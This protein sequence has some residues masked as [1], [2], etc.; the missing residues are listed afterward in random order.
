MRTVAEIGELELVERIRRGLPGTVP[1]LVQ[2]PGDDAAVVEAPAGRLVLTTDSQREGVHFRREQIDASA[3]GWRSLA[4]NVSDIAAMGARPAWA[5][6]A[7]AVPPELELAWVDAFVEGVRHC[8][9]ELGGVLVGGDVARSGDGISVTISLVGSLVP[10]REPLLRKGAGPGHG[11]WV[12]GWPGRSRAGLALL[13]AGWRLRDG[14]ARAPEGATAVEGAD[15][16]VLAHALPRPRVELA[17]AIGEA[18]LV[19][20][21][22]DISDGLA[23]DLG[24]LCRA[25]GVGVVVDGSALPTAGL[26]KVAGSIG[27]SA[28]EW[29][30]GGGED[31]ELLLAVA[32]EREARLRRRAEA[33]R[34]PIHRIG[35]FQEEAAVQLRIGDRL[36]PLAGGWD[37]F[38]RTAPS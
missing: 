14:E 37:H 26:E 13:H 35:T 17:E 10:G 9:Q 34:V 1:G 15:L 22:I 32:P 30:L 27:G 28:T 5:L 12:T 11:C 33:L 3:V 16:C 29:I 2:G 4:V 20:A 24:R 8:G 18:R 7:L 31:Y 21:A 23:I 6:C 38:S 36:E 25:S 19:A